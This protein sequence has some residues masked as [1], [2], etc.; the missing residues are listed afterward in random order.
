VSQHRPILVLVVVLVLVAL[1]LLKDLVVEQVELV[2]SLFH[3]PLDK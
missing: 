1:A 2:L 3:I